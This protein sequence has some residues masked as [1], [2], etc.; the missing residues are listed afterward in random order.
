MLM[1]RWK[2]AG[3]ETLC[4]VRGGYSHEMQLRT[5]GLNAWLK[6]H[7]CPMQVSALGG[8]AVH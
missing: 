3:S 5:S 2:A 6:K 1:L 4:N 7:F 8:G